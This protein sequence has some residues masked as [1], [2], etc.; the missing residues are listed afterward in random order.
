MAANSKCSGFNVNP[1]VQILV[2]WVRARDFQAGNH[3]FLEAISQCPEL[4]SVH[5]YTHRRFPGEA[6]VCNWG[7][8]LRGVT[9]LFSEK[10]ILQS[11]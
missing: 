4:I 6:L 7:Y 9:A 10:L 5:C 3:R 1:K 8:N 11:E 2:K